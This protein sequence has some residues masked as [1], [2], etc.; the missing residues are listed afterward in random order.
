MTRG[1]ENRLNLCFKH[2]FV[3]NDIITRSCEKFLL[4]I[5]QELKSYALETREL[6]HQF[7]QLRRVL[8]NF[9]Q[10]TTDVYQD[11]NLPHPNC[12]S[13]TVLTIF[14]FKLDTGNLER[15]VQHNAPHPSGAT[16]VE[17]LK[18]HNWFAFQSCEAIIKCTADVRSKREFLQV[19]VHYFSW[20]GFRRSTG[21]VIE[22][23]SFL[24]VAKE[25]RCVFDSVS[26]RS[27]ELVIMYGVHC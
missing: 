14:P 2:I 7:N 21:N 1:V 19:G 24:F 8:A 13:S 22:R 9:P 18:P 3:L 4:K 12:C 5:P 6:L 11:W 17:L 27:F 20:E 16:K 23:L 15:H 10:K 25:S 26:R